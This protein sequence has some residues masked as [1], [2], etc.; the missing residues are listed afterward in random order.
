MCTYLYILRKIMSI[1]SMEES[2][3]KKGGDSKLEILHACVGCRCS[4]LVWPRS[5]A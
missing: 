1:K 4:E 3:E 5:I 2:E